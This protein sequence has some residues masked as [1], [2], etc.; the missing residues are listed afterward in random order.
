MDALFLQQQGH[1]IEKTQETPMQVQNFAKSIL[2]LQIAL[3]VESVPYLW[4]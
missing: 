3:G 2:L 1:H 4:T